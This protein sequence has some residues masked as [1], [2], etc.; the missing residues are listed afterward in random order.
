M[1]KLNFCGTGLLLVSAAYNIGLY[2][3][4]GWYL[5]L[6]ML[7]MLTLVSLAL[8]LDYACAISKPEALKTWTVGQLF[9]QVQETGDDFLNRAIYVEGERAYHPIDGAFLAKIGA[10]PAVVLHP[11]K[12]EKS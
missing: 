1:I 5:V 4:S 7:A 8:R 3:L 10:A 12:E 6:V 2:G 9:L 11:A